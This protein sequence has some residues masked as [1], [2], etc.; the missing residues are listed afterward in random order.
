MGRQCGLNTVMYTSNSI[1]KHVLSVALA[2]HKA[3]SLRHK[4]VENMKGYNKLL[5]MKATF[6]FCLLG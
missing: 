1:S 6:G 5:I 2:T 4:F 3:I